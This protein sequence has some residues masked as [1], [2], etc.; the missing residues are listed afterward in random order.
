M[1]CGHEKIPLKVVFNDFEIFYNNIRLISMEKMVLSGQ[2]VVFG[3]SSIIKN[4]LLNV[5][6]CRRLK[7]DNVVVKGYLEMNDYDIPLTLLWKLMPDDVQTLCS[8]T[9]SKLFF[10][11]NFTQGSVPIKPEQVLDD[12]LLGDLCLNRLDKKQQWAFSIACDLIRGCK[13]LLVRNVGSS[14]F[15]LNVLDKLMYYTHVIPLIVVVDSYENNMCLGSMFLSLRKID[16]IMYALIDL[17]MDDENGYSPLFLTE[18]IPSG[19]LGGH[20]HKKADAGSYYSL[21]VKENRNNPLIVNEKN[22]SDN[23]NVVQRFF[24]VNFYKFDLRTVYILSEQRTKDSI[25]NIGICIR[26]LLAMAFFFILFMSNLTFYKTPSGRPTLSCDCNRH[27]KL[28][29]SIFWLKNFIVDKYFQCCKICVDENKDK[30]LELL[31]EI[32]NKLNSIIKQG[33]MRNPDR[34]V[35][36]VDEILEKIDT[37]TIQMFYSYMKQL[38]S[39]IELPIRSLREYGVY[40]IN[41]FYAFETLFLCIYISIEVYSLVNHERHFNYNNNN[42][43]YTPCTYLLSIIYHTMFNISDKLIGLIILFNKGYLILHILN[44]SFLCTFMSMTTQPKT[45]LAIINAIVFFTSFDSVDFLKAYPLFYFVRK[46]NPF[47]LINEVLFSIKLRR[48]EAFAYLMRFY[49][50]FFLLTIYKISKI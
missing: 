6:G 40:A 48:L 1:N 17:T 32:K 50:V 5:L 8:T 42:V 39:N 12:F 21:F 41:N 4:I 28:G 27:F 13:I 20:R 18:E 47:F 16:P 44:F 22:K 15:Y 46:I 7:Y 31:F 33:T 11:Y 10:I 29:E 45:S 49:I 9:R 35:E 19:L 23:I 37:Y 34:R 26:K 38:F 36:Y 3:A 14:F 43:I 2:V 24:N 30:Q 25:M